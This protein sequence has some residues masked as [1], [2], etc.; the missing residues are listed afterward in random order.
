MLKEDKKNNTEQLLKL[1]KKVLSLE[2]EKNYLEN[3]IEFCESLAN[4][5]RFNNRD[6]YSQKLIGMSEDITKLKT[7]N[8]QLKR[9]YNFMKENLEH[10]D[11]IN[12]QLNKT[13]TEYEKKN[14]EWEIKYR[15]MEEIFHKRD[16]QRQKKIIEGL[17]NMKLY[18]PDKLKKLKNNSN[19]NS[20]SNINTNRIN[21]NPK[22]RNN[23]RDNKN[24]DDDNDDG[25]NNNNDNHNNDN[26]GGDD[27]DEESSE[28]NNISITKEQFQKIALNEEKIKQL[29]EV[30]NKKDEEIQRLNKV[31][32]E[33]I[34]AIKK[35][36]D[37][38]E[39]ITVEKLVGKGG[40]NIIKNEETQKMAK[41]MHQTVKTLQEMIKQKT[42]EINYKDKLINNLHNELDKTKST[43]LQKIS[44]LEDQLRDKHQSALN[45]LQN[46]L[47][48]KSNFPV[49]MNRTEM[50]LN[51]M[52]DL[53]KL[54][55]D[56]D[57]TIRALEMELKSV[58]EENNK[59]YVKLSEKNKAI[60]DLEDKMK[61]MKLNQI[62]DYNMNLINK[63]KQ[64]INSKNEMIERE[65]EKIEE[66]KNNFMKNYQDKTL[67]EDDAKSQKSAQSVQLPMSA[68]VANIEKEKEKDDL[69]KQIHKLKLQ[70]GKLND[71]K[72]K[73]NKTI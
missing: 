50:S 24:D 72:K 64:E 15:K 52:N 46:L 28:Y 33:N 65:K 2:N 59:N 26:F 12:Q 5:I 35:G 13:I 22:N 41:T 7:A 25:N 20:N 10:I 63:L 68:P 60:I 69:K 1:K 51:N 30:I 47:D 62:N 9:E 29:N 67:I 32:E 18:R 21:I 19:S 58:K 55:T 49:K 40:Y 53:E 16:E 23:N 39:T 38:L 66:I 8:N 27:N 71:E 45:K 4:N 11:K 48:T 43:Y 3:E 34:N 42:A 73:L 54:L 70:I 31:N 44:L 56:K 17:E 6:E 37:F 61:M 14:A 57:N 36:Q